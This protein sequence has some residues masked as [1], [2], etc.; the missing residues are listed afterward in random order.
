MSEMTGRERFWAVLRNEEYDIIPA[1]AFT[2]VA[3]VDAMRISRAYFPAAHTDGAKMADLASV[4]HD[5][6][7]FDTVAPYFSVLLEAAA[8][9]SDISWGSETKSPF[10][11]KPAFEGL[12]DISIPDNF[13][14]KDEFCQLIRAISILR[15]KYKNN[16]AVIGKVIGPWTLAFNLYG[17]DKL[18]LDTILE[19]EKTKKLIFELSCIPVAFAKAQFEAG[20]D[21]VTWADHVTGDLFGPSIYRDFVYDVHKAVCKDLKPY[22]PII[23]HA[24]GN[25]E[26]RIDLF[27]AAGFDCFH[28]DSRND[29]SVLMSK[30]GKMKLVGGI[31]NPVVLTR[32]AP[33]MIKNAVMSNIKG[34]AA[35]IG[36]ECA[37]PTNVSTE[38]LKL[39]TAAVH[40]PGNMKYIHSK[41]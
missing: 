29:I 10:V 2:S 30:C 11:S 9:G 3:T 25:V 40:S 39:L 18:V 8:L 26:D 38:T 24:C 23:L 7:G 37:I 21:A 33:S 35:M 17:V 13:M 5:I 36:P 12:D 41:K 32:G 6:F 28:M 4:G 34:G 22:G 27:S 16:V 20:A 14:K 15:K 1:A 31:N 19:P